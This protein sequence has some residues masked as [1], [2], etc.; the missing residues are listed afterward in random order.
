[1]TTGSPIVGARVARGTKGKD[2]G[3]EVFVVLFV[4]ARMA[5]SYLPVPVG[6]ASVR[7]FGFA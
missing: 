3:G 6:A 2:V 5:M 7:T 4:M 1:M